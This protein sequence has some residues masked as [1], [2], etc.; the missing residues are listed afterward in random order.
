[1]LD[2]TGEPPSTLP[3]KHAVSPQGRSKFDSDPEE[4][5]SATVY[6]STVR[7]SDYSYE[8]TLAYPRKLNPKSQK[9]ARLSTAEDPELSELLIP[10]SQSDEE[11]VS[12]F[13]DSPKLKTN[14]A[15]NNYPALHTPRS[16][17]PERDIDAMQ[18]DNSA[19]ESLNPLD[20][21]SSPVV[22]GPSSQ[23]GSEPFD[24]MMTPPPSDLPSVHSTPV[25]LNPASKTA[26]IIADIK[27][28]A[29]AQA[30]S[31]P[32]NVPLEMVE[33]SDS[34][35]DEDDFLPILPQIRTTPTT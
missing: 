27:A 3:N 33:P 32:E 14:A 4:S 1:M 13:N 17:T 28:R 5:K 19:C 16:L 26:Q 29:Y 2:S 24:Q 35:S 7:I 20:L 6:V 25:A 15:D 22:E 34:S 18:I 31:S 12:I 10:S 11:E 23:Q 8:N 30:T 9:R 21:P